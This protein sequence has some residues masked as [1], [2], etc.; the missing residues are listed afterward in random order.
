MWLNKMMIVLVLMASCN[1]IAVAQGIRNNGANIVVTTG[2]WI[3]V[4]GDA[5]GGF[6]NENG[7][8]IDIDGEMIIEGNW[9]NNAANNVFT[10]RTPSDGWVR[11]QGTTT[12]TVGGTADTRF[13]YAEFNNTSAGTPISLSRKERKSVE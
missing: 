11:F 12:Q 4:D 2:S 8:L 6:L 3:Y 10:N 13:E 9:T 1:W 7:G 5:N